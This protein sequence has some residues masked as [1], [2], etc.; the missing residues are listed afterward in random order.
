MTKQQ[1]IDET[2]IM[3]EGDGLSIDDLNIN[4]NVIAVYLEIAESKIKSKLYPFSSGEERSMPPRYEHLK[5]EIAAY[6]INKRGAEG[7][8]SHSENGIDRSYEAGSVP[9]SMLREVKP[10]IKLF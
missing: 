3:V 5:C 4:D 2:R 8:L 7:Q 1:L 10:A 6:L 9:K